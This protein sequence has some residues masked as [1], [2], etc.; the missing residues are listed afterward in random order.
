MYNNC[1][2]GSNG[3][4][5]CDFP[6]IKAEGRGSGAYITASRRLLQRGLVY[7]A[8]ELAPRISAAGL[9]HSRQRL[10]QSYKSDRYSGPLE[11]ARILS[12]F[13]H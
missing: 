10:A 8:L 2:M 6:T 5:A 11:N 9:C 13:Q 4:L 12:V 1:L 7:D 3:P